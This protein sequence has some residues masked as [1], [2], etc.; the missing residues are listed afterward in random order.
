MS[1]TYCIGA[2][3]ASWSIFSL[4]TLSLAA[5]LFTHSLQNTMKS[6]RNNLTAIPLLS[7]SRNTRKVHAFWG[8]NKSFCTQKQP[9]GSA[10]YSRPIS[11]L[12]MFLHGNRMHIQTRSPSR[13]GEVS[14]QC[15]R[16]SCCKLRNT[17]YYD[18]LEAEVCMNSSQ[19]Q[20]SACSQLSSQVYA[21]SG[22]V[23][24]AFQQR[25]H[26]YPRTSCASPVR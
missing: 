5:W 26:R 23:E 14:T 3:A 24:E 13:A 16:H 22:C 9:K 19:L 21:V 17:V 8:L 25:D 7:A 11:N 2:V 1:P 10:S 4:N 15:S 20:L 12:F 6:A 18:K